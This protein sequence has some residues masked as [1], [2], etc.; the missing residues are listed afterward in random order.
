MSSKKNK[1]KSPL[2][3]I[4]TIA[5]LAGLFAGITGD[6]IFKSFYPAGLNPAYLYSDLNLSSLN[7]NRPN[8]VIRDAKKVVVSQDVKVAETINAV[9]PALLRIFK[10]I[11]VEPVSPTRVGTTSAASSLNL[12]SADI[13]YYK[14]DEPEFIALNITSDG[15]AIAD[16]PKLLLADF[17]PGDYVAIDSNRKL[18]ELDDVAEFK[19]LPGNLKFFHLEGASALPIR[20]V[21][22]R[23]DIYLGQSVLLISNLSEVNLSSISGLKV[24]G[25]VLSSDKLNVRLSLADGSKEEEPGSFIFNLAGDLVAINSPNTDLIPAFSYTYFWQKFFADKDFGPAHLGVNYLDLSRTFVAGLDRDKG[26]LLIDGIGVKA[27][28]PAGPAELAGLKAGDIITW[29]NNNELD[30]NNDLASIISSYSLGEEISL[31]YLREGLEH[32]LKLKLGQEK[33]I[34]K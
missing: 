12:A 14:L 4:V 8:L 26:A 21:A 20:P 24:P 11:N 10:K 9:Q 22:P 28:I 29:V 27:I 16:I 34:N 15:W 17:K 33:V 2:L 32:N 31:T 6:I 19:E 3:L 23:S 30:Q 5:V 1:Q 25:G 13:S 7:Y 18:Y